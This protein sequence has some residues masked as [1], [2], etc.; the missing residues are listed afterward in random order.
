MITKGMTFK[1]VIDKYPKTI[2]V[3]LEEGLHCVGCP[4]AG[5][6]TIE[7]GCKVHGIDAEKLIK[8][9]NKVIRK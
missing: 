5:Q 1:E 4:I 6:E 3:F 8:K 2:D 7:Q 9:L